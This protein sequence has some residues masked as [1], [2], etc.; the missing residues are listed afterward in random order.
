MFLIG[1]KICSFQFESEKFTSAADQDMQ[2]ANIAGKHKNPNDDLED[3]FTDKVR[4]N[5]GE[6]DIDKKERDRAIREHQE[7]E[8]TLDACE[9][10]FDSPK[11]EKQLIV[12]LGKNVYLSLPWHEGLTN[13]HCL[14][15]PLAH[16]TCSTQLDD[17]V[18]QE[19]KEYMTALNRMFNS[20]KQDVIFFET[21]RYLHRR[22]HLVIHCVPSSDFEMAPFYFKKAI[23]ESE[24][25]WA[26]NKQLVSLKDR[27]VRRAIPK[28]NIKNTKISKFY[29][30][31]KIKNHYSKKYKL[32]TES[33]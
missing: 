5:I 1:T 21:A 19:V 12:S 25:E 29:H 23:Q 4:K 26:T 3:I 33:S 27:D 14:I 2:F 20:R 13:N 17:D 11:L 22:P 15:T 31:S 7:M 32:Y 18:W 30:N 6:N 8:R 9:R 16:V 24:A 28:G 10:C